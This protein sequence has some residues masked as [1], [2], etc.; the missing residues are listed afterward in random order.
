MTYS[1][2]QMPG[3]FHGEGGA[4]AQ[5]LFRPPAVSPGPAS[6][7]SS[8][9]LDASATSAK[10]KRLRNG[11]G[12]APLP[13]AG[14]FGTSPAAPPQHT[15][16]K[17]YALAGRLDTPGADSGLLGESMYS[18][19]DFRTALGSKRSRSRR[20]GDDDDGSSGA[21]T[22]LFTVPSQHSQYQEGHAAPRSGWGSA[23]M[24]TLGGVVGRV[25]EFCKAGAFKGFYAGGGRGF[26][27]GEDG[28][29]MAAEAAADEYSYSYHYHFDDYESRIP[30]R[31]P[32]ASQGDDYTYNYIYKAA[33]ADA[34]AEDSDSRP[35]TPGAKRRQTAPA[36]DLGR[37]W[38]LVKDGSQRSSTRKTSSS[39]RPS[40]RNRNH[41][42]SVTTG[43]RISTT[44]SSAS[45][46][47]ANGARLS[48]RIDTPSQPPPRQ[49]ASTASFASPRSS[50]S[51][52]SGPKLA[53]AAPI[54]ANT[55]ASPAPQ[56]STNGTSTGTGTG[57]RRRRSA[58][59]TPSL[60][61][62]RT[63]SSA[64]AASSRGGG[65][66]E[67]T[68][69]NSP[70]LDAEAKQLAA[71]R[72]MDERNADVRIAA[73]NKRLQDMI[74]QGK[75]ALGTTIEVDGDEDGGGDGWIDE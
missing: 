57:H 26:A 46:V 40:P 55:T 54:R 44:P 23:A 67:M 13:S 32:A 60:G 8:G 49:P 36:D 14:L 29:S 61:H 65:G 45:A 72:K 10:R 38:V 22:S 20:D 9:F 33:A 16:S 53:P 50:P 6:A 66:E 35:S 15:P 56:R 27:V 31:F 17:V 52:A 69:E 1:G 51:H 59:T 12:E 19:S 70:R 41:A 28:S 75:E 73:F 11:D 62:R 47:P 48:Y 43:R 37:N 4:V 34:A 68:A 58:N 71:R 24:S 64:S 42:P 2:F 39:Y 7:S 25:W 21:P 5:P 63:Q 74:R 3:A 30:G 18:D